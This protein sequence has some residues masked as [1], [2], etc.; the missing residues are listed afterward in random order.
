MRYSIEVTLGGSK[1]T[2]KGYGEWKDI[3]EVFWFLIKEKKAFIRKVKV[4]K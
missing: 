2:L 4:E 3:L 1:R